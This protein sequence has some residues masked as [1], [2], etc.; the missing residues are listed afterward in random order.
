MYLKIETGYTRG[1]KGSWRF[2][3]F[4][5]S[6]GLYQIILGRIQIDIWTKNFAKPD[7]EKS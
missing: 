5:R 2:K 6:V 7:K 4:S 3:Y 1:Y